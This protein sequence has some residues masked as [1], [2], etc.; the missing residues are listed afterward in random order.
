MSQESGANIPKTYDP[1]SFERKWYA[2]WEEHDLFHDAA[3]ESREPYSVVIPPPNVTGQLHMGHALDNTL[4]DILVRYQRMRGKNVVW[5]PGCDHAGIATQAK[6]EESLRAEGTNRF[7]LGREKF[8]AHV[9]DWKQQY[10]DRIMYQLRML[11]AS[12]DWERE[13][14]TMDEGCSR[15]VREVFVSL[16]EQGLIYQGTR[17]TNWCPHCTTAISDIEVE[18]ET[19]EG[20]LWHLRYRIEGT[21]DYV[22]IATTRP[23]TMFGDTGVAVHPDDERYKHLVGKT[24]IL[25]VVER[26]IPLFADAYVD[27]AFGTGAVKVTPAHD[28]NDFEMGL[29]HNLEQVV[30]IN[31]DGTMGEGAGKYAGLDRYECRRKLVQE[32]AEIGALVRTEKHEHAVGHCSRCKTTIEPLV[33][34]Q[35]FVRMEDLAKPAIAAVKDGRIRFVPERFTK[36][37]ENWLENIRDWCISRQLWWGHRIPAWHCEDCGETSVSREDITACMHCGSTHI[38]QDEDV[39]DTWFSSGLW[40]FE[41]LGWPEDTEDLRHFYPTATLVTGYDII[42]FWVARMVMMGLRFGG[43]VP[44]RDVF[45]HGLVRDSEGRKMSKSLGNGIDPVEVIEK[46]GADTLRF[47][48]ITGN[49][50]GNDMRFYWERVEAARNFANKI[51]NASR[52]MLMNLEGADDAFVPEESDYTLADRWILTRSAETARAVTANLEHYELGEAGRAIYE[53][54]WSEFC[55]WYIELTKARL[56]DKENVRAKNTALYVL[57]TVLERTMRLLHPFM[58]FLTE[59]IWQKLPH[60]GRSIMRAPWPEVDEKEID[61]EAEAA[62]TAI[63]E[64]IKVT[65]NLRAE[66]GT[67]PGKKSALLLRVRDAALGDVFA[68]HTDYFHALASASEVTFLAEDAPDPENVV[69]GAL[70]GAA[71]YLPLAGLIDVEKE[72]ARLTKERDNLEKEIKRLTGKLS[73]AGF[74]SKAPAAVVAAEREKLAG[75]EEKIGLIRSRLADLAKL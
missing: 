23:E 73:N 68:A 53:F 30:V 70:A 59:E 54:L 4:Q 34:K 14:F 33:S 16:Y 64:V 5:I 38:H 12:C 29:R 42:F 24:L 65:R 26:R 6:V 58:P 3:D 51:W 72:T 21:D 57:R 35:W 31:A 36:I 47:M 27:P 22:E 2:Y 43:D 7:A 55:D 46:Y 49:T 66:L 8:L 10:G 28:P 32:L 56:Y 41:T 13:R 11:G 40:P 48:L 18:H 25:P 1:Q 60:E 67:P 9:W 61:A 37:Y 50:P 52:Y 17:I 69:T 19:E 63:M 45:I 39:L 62:M 20:H 75:Y 71:V 74:T 44:F 15:A